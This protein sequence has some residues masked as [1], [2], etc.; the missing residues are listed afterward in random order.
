MPNPYCIDTSAI[1]DAWT[2]SYRPKSFPSFWVRID[3]LIDTGKLV[4]P[5]EVRQE[6][7][8]PADL[9][10]WAK[11]HDE[12]F[13][14]L[15][16][17]LQSE[18]KGVLRDLHDLMKRRRLRFLV[19]AID[20]EVRTRRTAFVEI[21]RQL[22]SIDVKILQAMYIIYVEEE[23]A[24]TKRHG[25]QKWFKS[26]RPST[27]TEIRKEDILRSLSIPEPQYRESV[28]NLGRLGLVDSYFYEGTI[29]F[30]EGETYRSEDVV[31]SHG[32]Y[33]SLCI[34]ALGV[35]FVKICNYK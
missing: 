23:K 24:Y 1:I 2:E 30:E 27:W 22:E 29:D 7:K 13:L 16:I 14:E 25:N 15:D 19:S 34:T 21:L 9:V 32:G 12:L 4:S 17:D 18:L 6:I 20:P 26:D 33:D 11:N 10:E 35:A 8:Y 28:D 31:V 3:Q 5:E